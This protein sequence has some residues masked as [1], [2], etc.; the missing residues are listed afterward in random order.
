MLRATAPRRDQT[1]LMRNN[2]S[3][4]IYLIIIIIIII[5]INIIIFIGVEAETT[6]EPPL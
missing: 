4:F 5:I 3:L 2:Y 1:R 6:A